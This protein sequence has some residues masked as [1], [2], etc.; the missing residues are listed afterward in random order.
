MVA[1][2]DHE[3]VIAGFPGC[4]WFS[5]VFG[6]S[7]RG[8][9][10]SDVGASHERDL[11]VGGKLLACAAYDEVG[12]RTRTKYVLKKASERKV[13][14]AGVKVSDATAEADRERL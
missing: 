8:R 2:V 5:Q 4:R 6:L 12:I 7:A 3:E 11:G 13:P 14:L 9:A 10:I 1:L